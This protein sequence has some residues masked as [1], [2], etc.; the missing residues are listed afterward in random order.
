NG[1]GEAERMAAFMAAVN[2]GPEPGKKGKKSSK[3]E[4]LA[5]EEAMHSLEQVKGIIT[6]EVATASNDSANAGHHVD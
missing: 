4:E 1:N 3:R 6:R 5:P 2:D